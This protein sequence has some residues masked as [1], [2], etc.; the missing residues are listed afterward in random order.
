[1]KQ[2]PLL[3]L[4]QDLDYLSDWHGNEDLSTTTER[5][6]D[7]M[8]LFFSQYQVPCHPHVSTQTPRERGNTL[9][10]SMVQP[11]AW[12][13]GIVVCAKYCRGCA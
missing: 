2:S 7:S 11:P 4:L 10:E 8:L 6:V 5:V 13:R 9:P 1:M 3:G 12:V